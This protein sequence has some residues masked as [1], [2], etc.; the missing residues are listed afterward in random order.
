[1]FP[2]HTEVAFMTESLKSFIASTLIVLLSALIG[3]YLLR[4]DAPV[5]YAYFVT[6]TIILLAIFDFVTVVF[7]ERFYTTLGILVIPALISTILII[8]MF[9]VIESLN[10]FYDHLGYAFLTPFVFI[11]VLLIYA[12]IFLEKNAMLKTY[13]GINSVALLLLWATGTADKITMPF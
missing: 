13:L 6:C 1:M 10:R 5:H 9:V 2:S 4:S 7:I 11:A 8:F 12:A 3:T